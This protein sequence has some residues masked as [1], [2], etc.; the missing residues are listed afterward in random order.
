MHNPHYSEK[1][2]NTNLSELSLEIVRELFVAAKKVS[3][4]SSSH[5]ISGKAI[6]R[7][8]FQMGSVYRFKKYNNFHIRSGHLFVNNIELKP[9]VF[10]NQIIE[11]MRLY[12]FRL[13]YFVLA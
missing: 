8:F 7:L 2:L 13:F 10:A 6:G 3:V 11:Y 9:S 12:C 1:D 4:Y 5:P